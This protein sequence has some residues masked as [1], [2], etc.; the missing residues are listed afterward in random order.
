MLSL[1]EGLDFA[2]VFDAFWRLESPGVL[3]VMLVFFVLL[4]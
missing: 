2:G 3:E 4:R 1:M